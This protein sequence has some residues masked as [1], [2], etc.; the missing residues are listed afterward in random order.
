MALC[1]LS[2]TLPPCS[3]PC[4]FHL[5]ISLGMVLWSLSQYQSS[6]FLQNSLI[7]QYQ[8]WS[9][10]SLLSLCFIESPPFVSGETGEIIFQLVFLEI[11]ETTR[12]ESRKVTYKYLLT[13]F[14]FSLFIF[15]SINREMGSNRRREWVLVA[16]SKGIWSPWAPSVPYLLHAEQIV[17]WHAD[18]IISF[19][20]YLA[21]GGH[22]P[23]APVLAALLAEGKK[24][25]RQ[26][27]LPEF[28]SKL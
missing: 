17:H 1:I 6:G 14:T 21:N 16:D 7:L 15:L 10:R 2:S 18:W 13:L 9:L 3:P 8:G 19:T 22:G 23:E 26:S 12:K 25:R 20:Q 4:P 11:P 5:W 28:K 27:P 24:I